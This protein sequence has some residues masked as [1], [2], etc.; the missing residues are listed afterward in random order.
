MQKN[1]TDLESLQS[2]VKR[3]SDDMSLQFDLDNYVKKGAQ[4]KFKTLF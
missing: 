3:F 2:T 1:D 4:V